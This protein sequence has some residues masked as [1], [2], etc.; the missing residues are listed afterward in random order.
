MLNW[1]TILFRSSISYFPVHS[2]NFWEFNI[3]IPTKNLNLSAL[4][5]LWYIVELS[6]TIFKASCKCVVILSSFQKILKRKI[7]SLLK[8]FYL[9][10]GK[11]LVSNILVYKVIS[12]CLISV[13]GW[14]SDLGRPAASAGM[15]TGSPATAVPLVRGT[16]QLPL[17]HCAQCMFSSHPEGERKVTQIL[18]ISRRL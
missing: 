11:I 3:E 16:R 4:K 18:K 9:L 17:L 5:K 10:G 7:K 8:F 15:A 6:V 13:T 2:I 14:H 12:F 1:F